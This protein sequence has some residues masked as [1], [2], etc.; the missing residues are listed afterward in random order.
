MRDLAP[1]ITR[2]RLLVEGF[3]G[4]DVDESLVREAS[5]HSAF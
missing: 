1:D 4:R 5:E 3:Y 2:Q